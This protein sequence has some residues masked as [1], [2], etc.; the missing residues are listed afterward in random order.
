MLK[1]KTKK[2]NNYAKGYKTRNVIK[3]NEAEN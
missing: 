2:K 1:D 3:K